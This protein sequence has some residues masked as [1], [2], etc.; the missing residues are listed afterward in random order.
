MLVYPLE[1]IFSLSFKINEFILKNLIIIFWFYKIY[2][3][4][5]TFNFGNE[6]F[7]KLNGIKIL[8]LIGRATI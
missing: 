3:Q 5:T 6:W 2:I 4:T 8:N 1:K 7:N